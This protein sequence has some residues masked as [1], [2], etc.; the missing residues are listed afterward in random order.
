LTP[1]THHTKEPQAR[2]STAFHIILTEASII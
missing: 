2:L 1:L